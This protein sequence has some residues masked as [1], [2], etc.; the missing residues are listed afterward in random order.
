MMPSHDGSGSL[1]VTLSAIWWFVGIKM[2][3]L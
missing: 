2:P 1:L 3:N